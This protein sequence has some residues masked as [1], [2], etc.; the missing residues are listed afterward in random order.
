ME[1]LATALRPFTKE[2]V[3]YNI[4]IYSSEDFKAGL[5]MES[6]VHRAPLLEALISIDPRGGIF[7]QGTLSQALATTVTAE[8]LDQV[9]IAKSLK[10]HRPTD[11]VRA[12]TAYKLRVMLAHCR[13]KYDSSAVPPEGL[14]KVFELL[15][16]SSAGVPP[17][18]ARRMARLSKSPH[19]RL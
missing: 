4:D 16:S 14:H 8:G 10:H 5:S 19:T 7:A 18:K 12:L 6:L 17:K 13:M 9:L 2:R 1:T 11:E 3:E 15:Q